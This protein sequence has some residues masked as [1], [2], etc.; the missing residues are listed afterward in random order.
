MT[1]VFISDFFAEDILGGGEIC[2]ERVINHL[3]TVTKVEKIRSKDCS[4]NFLSDN[5]SSKFIIGNFVM[6]SEQVKSFITSNLDYSIYEH[7][8]KFVKNRNPAAY[9][10]FS[11]PIDQ[12][13]NISFYKGAK[14]IICQSKFQK[15]IIDSNLFLKN[16]ISLGTNFWTDK[17]YDILEA[18]SSSMKNGFC[19]IID[20]RIDHKNT[21]GA[22]EFCN[23][24]NM[25]SEKI[26]GKDY[27]MFLDMFGKFTSFAFF[28]KT[29]ETFSRT[30]VEARMMNMKLYT[31]ELV[32]CVHE[33]WFS[34]LVGTDLIDFMKRSNE[35]A[36][37][38]F[39]GIV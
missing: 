37:K 13:V 23:S 35:S 38:F 3:K 31:N 20:Y 30:C 2:T 7:D 19:A 17:Q 25:S 33:D 21:A 8:Y 12:L 36:L 39:E 10:N 26:S 27:E 4:I 15:N 24:R 34:N 22:V 1:V 6:L 9:K 18:N 11:V 5:A 28:P 16:T 32:G 14:Y 29:P